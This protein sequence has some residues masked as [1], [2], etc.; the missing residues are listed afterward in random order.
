MVETE[1][2]TVRELLLRLS[3]GRGHRLFAGTPEQVA[4]TIEEWFTTGAADGFNLIPPALPASLADFVDHVVPELQRRKIFREEYTGS[5]LRDH[6][7]LDRPAN[8]FSADT[9]APVSAAS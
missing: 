9:D 5:T 2:L 8:R 4:D 6:L 1:D 7:G 3:S